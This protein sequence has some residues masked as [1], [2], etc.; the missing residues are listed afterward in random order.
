MMIVLNGVKLKNGKTKPTKELQ[1]AK[2]E[3]KE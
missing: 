2:K 1:Y 3:I